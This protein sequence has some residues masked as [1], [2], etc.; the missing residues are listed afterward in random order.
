MTPRIFYLKHLFFG[1]ITQSVQGGE[2]VHWILQNVLG[3]RKEDLLR[4]RSWKK[5]AED[6]LKAPVSWAGRRVAVSGGIRET[7]KAGSHQVGGPV[8]CF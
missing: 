7:K 4:Q 3:W 5:Q 6:M 1:M 2:D 8:L